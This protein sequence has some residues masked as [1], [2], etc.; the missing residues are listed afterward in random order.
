MKNSFG[1]R[2]VPLIKKNG[3]GSILLN[4]LCLQNDL[5]MSDK[6]KS[7]TERRYNDVGERSCV[8]TPVCK[9]R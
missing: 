1:R 5:F 3:P 4:N 6:K 9:D 8:V 7:N 2:K